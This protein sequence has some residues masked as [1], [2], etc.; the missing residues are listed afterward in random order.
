MTEKSLKNL[1]RTVLGKCS[2]IYGSICVYVYG[3]ARSLGHI[4]RVLS[5]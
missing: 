1:R 4:N 5:S 3:N 2:D